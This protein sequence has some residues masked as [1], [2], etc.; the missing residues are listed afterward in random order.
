M[1]EGNI[2]WQELPAAMRTIANEVRA[3]HRL[4][5][6][7]PPTLYALKE[8]EVIQKE[9]PIELMDPENKWIVERSMVMLAKAGMQA[10]ALVSEAWVLNVQNVSPEERERI[11]GAARRQELHNEAAR[12]NTLM[13]GYND[14]DHSITAMA[15]IDGK[16]VQDWVCITNTTDSDKVGGR[17]ANI[18]S[19]V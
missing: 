18:Y 9:I 2:K 10:V 12:I 15:Q 14:P 17:F 16:K 3:H 4:L 19:R 5:G 13:V 7:T 8:G 6:K 1:T 11:E